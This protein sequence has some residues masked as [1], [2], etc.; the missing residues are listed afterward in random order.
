MRGIFFSLGTANK[1]PHSIKEALPI[2]LNFASVP[3]P[4]LINQFTI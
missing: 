3:A 4:K 1:P 2:A